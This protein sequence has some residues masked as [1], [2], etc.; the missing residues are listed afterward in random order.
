MAL[1]RKLAGKD[2]R[3]RQANIIASSIRVF[4]VIEGLAELPYL[5]P[6]KPICGLAIAVLDVVQTLTKL[7][8]DHAELILRIQQ[9][10]QVLEPMKNDARA[11]VSEVEDLEK[12]LEEVLVILK[13]EGRLSRVQRVLKMQ[14]L[15]NNILTC[16]AKLDSCIQRFT[17]TSL[18]RI[19]QL[20]IEDRDEIKIFRSDLELFRRLW[21]P[22]LHKL[23]G[24]SPSTAE[25]P[26]LVF[27]EYESG[28]VIGYIDRQLAGNGSVVDS[29]MV[30]LRVVCP[31]QSGME[32]LRT[33]CIGLHQRELEAC[34]DPSNIVLTPDG[35]PIVGHNLVING[36]KLVPM[37]QSPGLD[38]WMK[39]QLQDFVNSFTY[40][41]LDLSDWDLLMARKHGRRASHIRL[42]E[43]FTSHAIPSFSEAAECFES[44]LASLEPIY[45]RRELT[46]QTIRSSAIQTWTGA[47][48]YRPADAIDCALGDIGY[49]RDDGKFVV[50][51]NESDPVVLSVYED[52][53][54][55]LKSDSKDIV[56]GSSNG[57]GVIRHQFGKTHFASI[58]HSVTSEIWNTWDAWSHL[59]ARAKPICR[60]FSTD[61]IELKITDLVFIVGVEENLRVST[62]ERKSDS[63]EV[64]SHVEYIES[65]N[66]EEEPPWGKWYPETPDVRI[67][68]KSW[69]QS[70]LF[71]QLEEEDVE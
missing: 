44:L 19:Y 21:H 51:T 15:K 59:I 5:S 22:N 56:K 20:L 18:L 32:Y 35:Q 29:F 66:A 1:H 9:L 71:I 45:Q 48:V 25:L 8:D 50:L 3:A 42:L 70:L 11:T 49:M 33:E 54:V 31:N 57:T 28:G 4:R 40:R 65:E 63:D 47:Y 58:R 64:P 38:A 53:V 12:T 34:F 52:S 67:T 17:V 69:A 36:P 61:E 14:E 55:S 30:A 68:N 6:L 39:I 41:K 2:S 60:A 7:T 16:T 46:F 10:A 37:Q 23:I 27:S 26:F 13:A 24:Q 43:H 62:F